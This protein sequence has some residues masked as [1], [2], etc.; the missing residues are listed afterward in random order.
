MNPNSPPP[1]RSTWKKVLYIILIVIPILILLEAGIGIIIS[2]KGVSHLSYQRLLEHRGQITTL[3]Y[4][5][6]N[7]S[8]LEAGEK[9]Y[10]LQSKSD[11]PLD[12]TVIAQDYPETVGIYRLE[13]DHTTTNYLQ[14]FPST[15]FQDHITETAPSLLEELN[16][17]KAYWDT[18]WTVG[19]QVADRQPL[20]TDPI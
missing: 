19:P 13:D 3:V 17:N 16:F 2:V 8:V 7:L 9:F 4:N 12:M 18:N 1:K 15:Q 20:R 14:H 10:Y 6:L 5:L 11:L